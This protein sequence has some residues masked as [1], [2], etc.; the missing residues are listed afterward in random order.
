MIE[1]MVAVSVFLVA[2]TITA[3]VFTRSI[4]TQRQSN[5]ITTASS[6]A[7]LILE[8]MAR[9][10]RSGYSFS[11]SDFAGGTDNRIDFTREKDAAPIAV[12][13]WQDGDD[14]KRSEDGAEGIL[15]AESTSVDKLQF[16]LTQS[17]PSSDPWRITVVLWVSPTDPNNSH[18]SHLQ[19]TVS[20]RI[21]PGELAQ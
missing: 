5:Q 9:E 7:S 12:S 8:R 3:G 6:D 4:R 14:I 2:A 17:D 11:I 18:I 10:I 21:L 1:L 15:N 16:I 20:A 13:Y 19:T